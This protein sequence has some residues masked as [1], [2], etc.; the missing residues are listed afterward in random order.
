MALSLETVVG[1][2]FLRGQRLPPALSATRLQRLGRS[3]HLKLGAPRVHRPIACANAGV[4][5][6]V[7]PP[8][9]TEKIPAEML[10]MNTFSN[11]LVLKPEETTNE[12]LFRLLR[13]GDIGHI[14]SIGCPDGTVVDDDKRRML[15]F[16]SIVLQKIILSVAQP[17]TNSMMVLMNL[18]AENDLPKI[19]WD[20]FTGQLKLPD[21]NSMDF[22]SPF[23]FIDTRVKLEQNIKPGDSAYYPHLSIMAA[24][25]SYENEARIRSI[26]RGYWDMEFLGFFNCWDDFQDSFCTQA[27]MMSDKPVESGEAELVV[28]A[29]RGTDDAYDACTDIDFSWYEIPGVGKVH[30]GF[31]K[32]LGLQ[33]E[34][35]PEEIVQDPQTPFAYYV[36][37]ER[38]RMIL[39]KNPNA[40]LVVTGHSLGGALSALF[41]IVLKLHGENWIIER[42]QGV[43]TFGQPRVGDRQLGEFAE[44]ILDSPKRRYFRFV[45]S[46]DLVPRVPFDDNTWL[47]KHFGK[48]LY[49]DSLYRGQEVHEEPNHNY[50]A[51]EYSIPKYMDAMWELAQSF[52]I[53]HVRGPEFHESP[54]MRMMRMI[55]LMIPGLPCHSPQDYN[56]ITR[57][58]TLLD[59]ATTETSDGM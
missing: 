43:Y 18:L 53:G 29:F 27:F 42:I 10:H 22:K 46:N 45:Y 12:E 14:D 11:Y 28:V 3:S 23:A 39:K 48:C 59:A 5:T 6:L 30:G 1:A 26:V 56:N 25:L 16:I 8:P 33:K 44:S 41:P 57:L 51:V 13:D 37:R 34:G 21:P 38:L 9:P 20:Y 17:G 47:F 49:Y 36:I 52:V 58:G 32:A 55:G 31:M 40:K 2:R 4:D 19:I 50:F 54:M 35:L 24:K 7:L 15:I